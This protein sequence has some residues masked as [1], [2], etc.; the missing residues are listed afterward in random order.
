MRDAEPKLD[1]CCR[2]MSRSHRRTL[3]LSYGTDTNR[4][5]SIPQLRRA[6]PAARAGGDGCGGGASCGGGVVHRHGGRPWLVLS[7]VLLAM[8]LSLAPATLGSSLWTRLPNSRDLVFGDLM[9]W[10]MLRR[11]RAD[12]RLAHA[13]GLLGSDPGAPDARKLTLEHRR[14]IL[15]RLAATLE[16]KDVYTLRHSRRVARHAE[17]IARELGLSREDVA[18]VRTAASVHDIG[19]VHT[20]RQIF[21]KSGVLSAEELAVMQRHPVDG[22]R[23]VAQM[24]DPEVTSMVRHH[25]ERLDGSGYPDGLRGDEDTARVED[26]LGGGYLRCHHLRQGVR[27]CAKAPPGARR[28]V[29][30]GWLAA[31]PRRGGGLPA[32]LLK[33]EDNRLVGRRSDW[34]AATVDLD[35]RSRQRGRRICLPACAGP[36]R[37]R[38]GHAGQHLPGA[39]PACD[40]GEQGSTPGSK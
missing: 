17:R 11:L 33:Q 40:R 23:M 4:S 9:L 34:P 29:G 10:G 18:R 24:G 39:T 30:G 35:R 22:A 14:K 16:A 20:P 26:H 13:Q 38:G 1:T 15:Q 28:A 7:S 8:V 36:R 32:V 27:G 6:I 5:A 2:L 12:R 21:T 25:H 31:R 37:H 19:K 3:V